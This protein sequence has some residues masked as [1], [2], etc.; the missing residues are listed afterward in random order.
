M[1]PI[2]IAAAFAAVGSLLKG[3]MGYGE[4]KAKER[5]AQMA[6]QQANADAGIK[7]QASLDQL[8]R[9]EAEATVRAAQNG[10]GFSGSTQDVLRD[11]DQRGI[12]NARSLIYAGATKAANY[13]YEGAVA[14]REGSLKLISG[15][16]SAGSSLAGG[17]ADATTASAS[18]GSSAGAG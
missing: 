14:S 13:R 5:Q 10:G 6:A 1:D 4:G 11:M 18:A 8:D 17:W 12:F 7:A 15:V 3:V 9:T 2:T 16:V